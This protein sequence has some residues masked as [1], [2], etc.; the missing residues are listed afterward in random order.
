ME[1]D[2]NV[3]LYS[4]GQELWQ[5]VEE[6][7]SPAWIALFFLCG[8]VKLNKCKQITTAQ[9]SKLLALPVFVGSPF[10]VLASPTCQVVK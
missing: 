3:R 7:T 2:P 6:P 4:R 10:S 9:Q 1:A 5:W 8:E